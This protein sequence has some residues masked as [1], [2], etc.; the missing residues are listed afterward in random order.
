MVSLPGSILRS[1]F[2]LMVSLPGSIL[3]SPFYLEDICIIIEDQ[4]ERN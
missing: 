2:Y 3:R 1:P 4:K